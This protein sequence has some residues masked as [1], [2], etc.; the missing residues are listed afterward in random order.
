MARYFKLMNPTRNTIANKFQD[1]KKIS[2]GGKGKKRKD[3]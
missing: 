2:I 3:P 1:T